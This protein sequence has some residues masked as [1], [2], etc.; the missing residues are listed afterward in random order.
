MIAM[1]TAPILWVH[2]LVNVTLATLV[3]DKME[4]VQVCIPMQLIELPSRL[5]T[6]GGQ[7]DSLMREKYFLLSPPPC[8]PGYS[9]PISKQNPLHLDKI[10]APF[11]MPSL[12]SFSSGFITEDERVLLKRPIRHTPS[13]SSGGRPAKR[14]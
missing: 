3:M 12:D 14:V 10:P 2:S 8:H 6:M 5:Y 13:V 4:S 1:P 9:P 11:P 7:I